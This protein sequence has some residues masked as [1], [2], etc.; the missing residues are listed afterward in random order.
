[1]A[2]QY[3]GG[4]GTVQSASL[5]ALSRSRTERAT[6][7]SRPRR[8]GEHRMH[9]EMMNRPLMIASLIEHA[10]RYHPEQAIASRSVEGPIHHYTYRDAAAR[11]RQLAN[12][13][14]SIGIAPGDRVATL[15]WNTYRHFELYYGVSG[16]G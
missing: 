5:L 2:Q 9:G 10:A 11:C 13:L 14:L 6:N 7:R 1:M 8:D 16:I 12:A 4:G 15:A 3:L